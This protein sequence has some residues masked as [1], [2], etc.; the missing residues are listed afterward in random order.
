MLRAYELSAA[1]NDPVIEPPCWIVMEVDPIATCPESGVSHRVFSF[2]SL[3]ASQ[4]CIELERRGID[5][6]S[7]L[8]GIERF[9]QR[10][11][12]VG[13]SP[14]KMADRY[15]GDLLGDQR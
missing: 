4:I 8:H 3:N 14:E 2:T 12:L 6:L 11:Y 10:G 15:L 5:T 1:P 7:A 9:A 13:L